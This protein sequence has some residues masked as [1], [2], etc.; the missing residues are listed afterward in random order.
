LPPPVENY[1]ASLPPQAL[2]ILQSMEVARAVGGP[3][4]VRDRILRF[5]E[6]TRADELIVSGAVFDTEARR[7]SLVLTMEALQ[8]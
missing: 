3:A 5:I 7:R 2:A 4:T 6:R 8:T 1:R